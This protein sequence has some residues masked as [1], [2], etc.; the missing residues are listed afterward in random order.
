M[1]ISVSI[2]C[3]V[4]RWPLKPSELK[5]AKEAAEKGGKD[6][7]EEKKEESLLTEEEERE[8]AELMEDSD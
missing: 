4:R 2:D 1:L 8:L 5:V 3:T 6:V 7:V